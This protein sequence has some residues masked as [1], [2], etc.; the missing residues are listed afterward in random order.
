MTGTD[1]NV[2]NN[3]QGYLSGLKLRGKQ[4]IMQYVVADIK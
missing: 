2:V 3:M 1:C 4:K